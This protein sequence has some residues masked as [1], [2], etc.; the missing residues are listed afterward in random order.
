MHWILCSMLLPATQGIHS[1]ILFQVTP[2]LAR[3]ARGV[4][5]YDE[6]AIHIVP[7][8]C[9]DALVLPAASFLAD[10]LERYGAIRN[11]LN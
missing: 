11:E 3:S 2:S 5:Q 7:V 9:G 6:I 4:S 10:G 1:M 8:A